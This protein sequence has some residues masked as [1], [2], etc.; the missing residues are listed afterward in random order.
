MNSYNHIDVKVPYEGLCSDKEY[1]VFIPGYNGDKHVITARASTA[2]CFIANNNLTG[3]MLVPVEDNP[4]QKFKII[5]LNMLISVEEVFEEL[6]NTLDAPA[7][8]SLVNAQPLANGE[9]YYL[10]PNTG[11]VEKVVSQYLIT[12]I[13]DLGWAE[14][15]TEPTTNGVENKHAGNTAI[16]IYKR[17]ISEMIDAKAMETPQGLN[18]DRHSYSAFTNN[19]IVCDI[20]TLKPVN[21]AG[22]SNIH[23][24][25]ARS[26]SGAIEVL[27]L[28]CGGVCDNGLRG[29]NSSFESSVNSERANNFSH[30][31]HR[32]S[33]GHS[34][35]APSRNNHTHY[36]CSTPMTGYDPLG[37][38]LPDGMIGNNRPLAFNN[39]RYRVSGIL[40]D[41]CGA[42]KWSVNPALNLH[43]VDSPEKLFLFATKMV[44]L[45]TDMPKEYNITVGG[46]TVKHNARD[47]EHILNLVKSSLGDIKYLREGLNILEESVNKHA[48]YKQEHKTAISKI[49][50]SLDD[51]TSDAVSNHIIA[52]VNKLETDYERS[53]TEVNDHFK[54][55]SRVVN[56]LENA[57]DVINESLSNNETH[58]NNS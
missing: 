30:P 8:Y 51:S 33:P 43:E 47:L 36:G 39:S 57:L 46:P 6:K 28:I 21:A 31:N 35:R 54:G 38:K 9:R 24:N 25:G 20:D 48:S 45:Y 10:T 12:F 41:I 5:G 18:N 17:A 3:S 52:G 55:V 40:T 22:N 32:G 50:D 19:L 53:I 7:L 13:E 4:N 16:T 34:Y 56:I 14:V 26:I 15:T 58:T 42:P 1:R 2:I 27:Q 29:F 23:T 11:V 49:K 37:N 44:D